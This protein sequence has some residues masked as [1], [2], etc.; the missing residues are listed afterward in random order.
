MKIFES[1]IFKIT[2]DGTTSFNIN[3][4]EIAANQ[5]EGKELLGQAYGRDLGHCVYIGMRHCS[6][7]AKRAKWYYSNN[8]QD[9]HLEELKKVQPG[10]IKVEFYGR[11]ED[12]QC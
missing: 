1:V 7:F 8:E 12:K 9:K 5:R 4:E 3:L 2:K 10:T 6:D 11:A